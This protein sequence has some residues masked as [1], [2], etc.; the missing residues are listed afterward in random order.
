MQERP[1]G[2]LVDA[3]RANGKHVEYQKSDGSLPLIIPG[4]EPLRQTL[5]LTL[6]A[7]QHP[8]PFPTSPTS[9]LRSVLLSVQVVALLVARFPS[10]PPSAANMCPPFSLPPHTPRSLSRG[11]ASQSPSFPNPPSSNP[12]ACSSQAD[13]HHCV[14]AFY[15]H[16]HPADGDLWREG[17]EPGTWRVPHSQDGLHQPQGRVMFS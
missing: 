12:Q 15:R 8:R 17:H 2:P 5:S 10:Q 3:L 6:Q 7:S 1:I 14:A 13:R 16:D 4:A 11:P 9:L